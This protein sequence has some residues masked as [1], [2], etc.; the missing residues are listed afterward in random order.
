[1]NRLVRTHVLLLL[2]LSVVPLRAEQLDLSRAVIVT[3]DGE[4]PAAEKVASQ[5]LTEELENAPGCN[6]R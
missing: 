1:M 6:C 3:R 4:L 2:T 5:V